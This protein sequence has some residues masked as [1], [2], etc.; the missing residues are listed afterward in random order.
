MVINRFIRSL[1]PIIRFPLYHVLTRAGPCFMDFPWV[2]PSSMAFRAAPSWVV[3]PPRWLCYVIPL[4]VTDAWMRHG[5]PGSKI[6][7]STDMGIPKWLVRHWKIHENEWFRG[8]PHFGK[9][10]YLG[11]TMGNVDFNSNR[12]NWIHPW[13]WCCW[14]M[15]P[16]LMKFVLKY[17]SPGKPT[18][19]HVFAKSQTRKTMEDGIAL[20]VLNA[21]YKM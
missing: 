10:P 2:F 4:I 17:V 6:A 7:G 8:T 19:F 14:K 13:K 9:P 5:P 3:S 15:I 18:N 12:N 20:N 21:L 11:K 1:I 16:K